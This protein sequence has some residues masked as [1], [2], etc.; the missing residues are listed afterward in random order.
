MGR[1]DPLASENSSH[2]G[3]FSLLGKRKTRAACTIPTNV[4]AADLGGFKRMNEC[5]FI[6]LGIAA[7]VKK[8]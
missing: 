8:K 6:I 4:D 2:T 5:C 7:A 1:C 3:G